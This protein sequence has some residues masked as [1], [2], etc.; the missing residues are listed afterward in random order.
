MTKPQPVPCRSCRAP[1]FWVI[2]ADG[3]RMPVNATPDPKGGFVLTLKST[4]ELH[5]EVAMP[6]TPANR[7]RYVS[8]FATC[9]QADQ[10][11]RSR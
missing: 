11:R 5:A 4:G 8:H 6:S 2:T 1:M 3:K 7:N 9:P 10:H